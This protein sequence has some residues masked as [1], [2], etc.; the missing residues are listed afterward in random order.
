MSIIK[1]AD[2]KHQYD[3]SCDKIHHASNKYQHRNKYRLKLC[4]CAVIAGQD[5][6]NDSIEQ[7]QMLVTTFF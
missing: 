4:N 7:L 1:K 3:K 2:V 5:D 6:D